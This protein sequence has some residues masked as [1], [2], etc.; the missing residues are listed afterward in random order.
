MSFAV[1]LLHQKLAHP[2]VEVVRILQDHV[3]EMDD[4]LERSSEDFS[5]ML[6]DVRT[7][8]AYLRLPLQN[9]PVFDDMLADLN[10]RS[11]IVAYNEKINTVINRFGAAINDALK[12][13]NKGSEG[14]HVLSGYLWNLPEKSHLSE[15]DNV[16]TVHA[17]Y[18]AMVGNVNG[19]HIALSSL[20]K[21]RIRLASTLDELD[22]IV[23]SLQLR[24]S[25]A[26]KKGM[27]C[28]NSLAFLLL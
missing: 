17:I 25:V 26:I 8:I 11:S 1:H 7:R 15:S 4:F 10:F 22:K 19:W 5:L 3:N 16:N 21:T 18:Q 20:N 6:R 23:K 14:V 12:D 24:V 13:L 9:L 28:N 27:F 2:E